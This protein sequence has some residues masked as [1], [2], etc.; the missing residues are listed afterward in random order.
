MKT[1]SQNHILVG[2]IIVVALLLYTFR[3]DLTCKQCQSLIERFSNRSVAITPI[4]SSTP[5]PSQ[6]FSEALSSPS[7]AERI[8]ATHT[9]LRALREYYLSTQDYAES[10]EPVH[11]MTGIL[12]Q[13]SHLLLGDALINDD[14]KSSNEI[15]TLAAQGMRE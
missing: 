2:A 13:R 8:E 3:S 5:T 7:S 6:S 10:D 11:V 4:T 1:L 9:I 15:I 12:N 14:T